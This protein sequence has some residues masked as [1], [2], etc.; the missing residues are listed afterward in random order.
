MFKITV[1]IF[2]EIWSMTGSK[3]QVR[4]LRQELEQRDIETD[5]LDKVALKQALDKELSGIR[6]PPALLCTGEPLTLDC[7]EITFRTST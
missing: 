2:S 7:Y 5:G 1:V 3:I 4:T 6:R